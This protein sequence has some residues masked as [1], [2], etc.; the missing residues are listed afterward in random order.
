MECIAAAFAICVIGMLSLENASSQGIRAASPQREIAAKPMRIWKSFPLAEGFIHQRDSGGFPNA[1][2]VQYMKR[3]GIVYLR[4]SVHKRSDLNRFDVFGTLPQ[5]YRP[6]N[7][8]EFL[9]SSGFGMAVVK[10]RRGGNVELW[11]RDTTPDTG[12]V[13]LDGI[14]FFTA[15]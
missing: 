13:S 5:G 2:P 6:E 12:T 9:Q 15:E 11:C 10:I 1:Q 8:L 4:G 14:F 3:D 7:D